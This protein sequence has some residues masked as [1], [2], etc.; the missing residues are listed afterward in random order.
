[1]KSFIKDN[2]FTIIAI[3]IFLV[4]VLLLVQVKNIFFPNGKKAIYGDRLNGIENVQISKTKQSDVIK[5][6]KD[7]ASIKNAT[8]RISG[9]TI[10]VIITVNDDIDVNTAKGFANKS[11]EQFSEEQKKF[12]DFQVFIKK[13]TEEANFPIIGYKHHKKDNFTFTKDRAVN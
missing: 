13:D 9:K 7:D 11:L 6:L 2:K 3:T 1:M 8:V 5:I 10:E 4:I 12:Y